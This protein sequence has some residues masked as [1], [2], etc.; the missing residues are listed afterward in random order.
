MKEAAVCLTPLRNCFEGAVPSVLATCSPDGVPNVTYLSQ[1]QYV[2]ERHVALTFQ[3]F[4]KTRRNILAN[5]WAMLKVVDPFSG[6]G[7]RLRVRY[8]RTETSGAL[9]ESMKAK[10]AGIASH[11]GMAEVF[12]LLG[13]DVYE[14]LQVEALPS[15][16]PA[17]VPAL[18][19]HLPRLRRACALLDASRDLD[20]LLDNTLS[21]LERECGIE[22]QMILK[23]DECGERLFT[24]A[25]RGYA[26]SGVGS[27]IPM[28]HG[29]IGVAAR[30]RTP[31]RIS[32]MTS[33]YAYGKAVRESAAAQG[34]HHQLE[35][36][37]P[38]PGLAECRSQM[39]VP[40]L[41]G[42]ALYGVLYVESPLDLRFSYDD[43]DLLQVLAQQFGWMARSL[44]AEAVC[45][46][47]A[48]AP[49]PPPSTVS[50]SAAA[51]ASAPEKPIAPEVVAGAGMVAEAPAAVRPLQVRYFR[52]DHSVFLD[53][54]YLIKGLAG[55][56][57]WRLMQ[58][59]QHKGRDQFSNRELRLDPQLA[60]PE[61]ADNLEA[62]LVLLQR[63]LAERSD[64]VRMRKTGR[65]RFA[66]EVSR[67]LR[68][69]LVE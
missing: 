24:V 21:A 60:L 43:E 36:A 5:P 41:A 22:H 11:T 10:L 42:Q 3:F 46:P 35:T 67:P 37:I 18:A 32:H 48:D 56:I 47:G 9:F 50:A 12:R 63:R 8:L 29:V 65:G 19:D 28:G 23:L 1:V 31:I 69:V 2:D 16:A 62:R 20:E 51:A 27:E 57:L 17:P 4:N 44:A 49:V 55:A 53:E 52:A 15:P 40:I 25:S 34:L 66:L 54:D 61:V 33:E 6:H 68:L 64:C 14:V 26:S 7:W 13:A 59:L 45:E 30:E 58:T 38:M 39:A